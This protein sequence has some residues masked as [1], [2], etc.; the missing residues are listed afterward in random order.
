[1]RIILLLIVIMPN[2]VIF[3][4][5]LYIAHTTEHCKMYVPDFSVPWLTIRLSK[6]KVMAGSYEVGEGQVKVFLLAVVVNACSG[7]SLVHTSFQT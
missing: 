6:R 5:A 7:Y 2:F 3:S 1:M 4:P